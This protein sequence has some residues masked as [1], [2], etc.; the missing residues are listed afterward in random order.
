MHVLCMCELIHKGLLLSFFF[1]DNYSWVICVGMCCFRTFVL[2]RV[3]WDITGSS[4]LKLSVNRDRRENRQTYRRTESAVKKL[5]CHRGC[6]RGRSLS[7]ISYG[8]SSLWNGSLGKL[9]QLLLKLT[10]RNGRQYYGFSLRSAG[11]RH[12]SNLSERQSGDLHTSPR[13]RQLI[14]SD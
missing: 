13:R 9:L 5:S 4:W 6:Q 12:Q 8:Y 2:T 10:D 11:R 14:L 7:L 3:H 1:A